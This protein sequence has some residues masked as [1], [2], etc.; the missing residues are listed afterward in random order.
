MLLTNCS[1]LSM[2]EHK[3]PGISRAHVHEALQGAKRVSCADGA[4]R[5]LGKTKLAGAYT[6]A[7]C[8]AWSLAIQRAA[9]PSSCKG[10]RPKS[11]QQLVSELNAAMPCASRQTAEGV[12]VTVERSLDSLVLRNFDDNIAEADLYELADASASGQ[13]P[14]LTGAKEYIATHRV[15]FGGGRIRGKDRASKSGS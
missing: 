15:V 13:G 11:D 6:H 12:Q 3:C 10:A 1:S 9:P 2:F 4:Y 5:W 8:R 14:D 7:L